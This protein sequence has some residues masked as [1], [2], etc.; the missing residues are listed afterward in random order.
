MSFNFSSERTSEESRRASRSFA[1]ASRLAV[2]SPSI[3][4]ISRA[5]SRFSRA[6]RL[7]GFSA[8]AESSAAG[9]TFRTLVRAFHPSSAAWRM[10]FCELTPAFAAVSASG[11]EGSS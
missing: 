11:T 8:D 1:A 3:A 4:S 2:A 6:A 5:I 10:S 7:A 9:G